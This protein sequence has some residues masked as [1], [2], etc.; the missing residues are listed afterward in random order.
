MLSADEQ[1]QV[2]ALDVSVN[3]RVNAAAVKFAVH[4]EVNPSIGLR[5]VSSKQ[6]MHKRS[7]LAG[8]HSSALTL[9]V[10]PK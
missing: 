3:Q 7:Y 1:K 8:V 10:V 9:N 6:P 5:D 4:Y 2:I